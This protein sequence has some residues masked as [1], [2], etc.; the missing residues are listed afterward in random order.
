MPAVPENVAT[1]RR[2]I[3]GLCDHL[4]IHGEVADDIRLAVTEACAA[5]I[6]HSRGADGGAR[7]ALDANVEG[8]SLL[9]V[10][11]DFAGG[12]VRGPIRGGNRG[13]RMGLVKR[14]A[15]RTDVSSLATGGLRVTMHFATHSQP[16]LT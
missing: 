8:E 4:E 15:E 7:F 10:V 12:L 3:T 13:V 2:A 9:V 16:S 5:C 11:R 14:L 6:E 1:A